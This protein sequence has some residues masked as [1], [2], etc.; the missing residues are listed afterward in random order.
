HHRRRDHHHRRHGFHRCRH[1]RSPRTIRRSTSRRNRRRNRDCCKY[2]NIDPV[3]PTR[4][5]LLFALDAKLNLANGF[6]YHT[7]CEALRR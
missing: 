7:D 5:P 3:R 4:L 6:I 1:R 2:E